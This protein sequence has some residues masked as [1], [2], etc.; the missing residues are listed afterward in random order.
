[1]VYREFQKIY[2]SHMIQ[3]LLVAYLEKGGTS[4]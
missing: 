4:E 1:M 3:Y 2:S